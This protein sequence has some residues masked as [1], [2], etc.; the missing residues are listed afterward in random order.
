L[1]TTHGEI[2]SGG[3]QSILREVAHTL[4]APS[5]KDGNIQAR[6]PID[7]SGATTRRLARNNRL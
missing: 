1:F 4:A 5:T 6:E 3:R 2:E 7:H